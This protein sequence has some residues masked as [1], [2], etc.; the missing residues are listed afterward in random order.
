MFEIRYKS[1]QPSKFNQYVAAFCLVTDRQCMYL[2]Y[3]FHTKCH[4]MC[5]TF[6]LIIIVI[7]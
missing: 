1:I 3:D 2:V 6:Y 5:I 7:K 4:W